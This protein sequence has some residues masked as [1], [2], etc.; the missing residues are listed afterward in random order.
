MTASLTI[1]SDAARSE[2]RDR[3]QERAKVQ[4]NRVQLDFAPRSMERLNALKLKTE[5]SSYAEVV[6][7][8]LR[9]Y[10]ALIEETDNGKQFLDSGQG[11]RGVAVQVVSV[12]RL[13][14]YFGTPFALSGL[15]A[16]TV[17]PRRTGPRPS[18]ASNFVHCAAAARAIPCQGDT[19]CTPETGADTTAPVVASC[20]SASRHRDIWAA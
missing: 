10:E 11:W 1:A 8:A 7:N 20:A 15:G 6:K 12:R 18:S 13:P 14:H 17:R 3:P 5:A 16:S 2:A 9:L 19:C 4:K